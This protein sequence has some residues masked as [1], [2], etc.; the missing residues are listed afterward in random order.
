MRRRRRVCHPH[1]AD[2]EPRHGTGVQKCAVR[3]RPRREPKQLR[4]YGCPRHVSREPVGCGAARVTRAAGASRGVWARAD[5]TTLW[6]GRAPRIARAGGPPCLSGSARCGHEAG[7]ET[8]ESGAAHLP[9]RHFPSTLIKARRPA[10]SILRCAL[11]DLRY[12]I[13]VAKAVLGSSGERQTVPSP[14][15]ACLAGLAC[16]WT[17]S[18]GLRMRLRTPARGANAA[19]IPQ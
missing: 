2:G 6:L 15:A 1:T 10:A 4:R 16:G 3:A 5:E 13:A 14:V 17:R 19:W 11:V 8:R 7:R 18:P 9:S 12:G